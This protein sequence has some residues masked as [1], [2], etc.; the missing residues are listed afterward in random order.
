M[1]NKEDV[2]LLVY[3]TGDIHGD[4]E[5]FN[6]P[7][8]K[9]LKKGDTLI[10]CGDFGFI[11]NGGEVEAKALTKLSSKKFNICFVDGTHENFKIL[12]MA[13]ISEWNG[14]KVHHLGGNLYHLLRG[15]IFEIEGNTYFTM[16]GGESPDMEIRMANNTWS[17]LEMPSQQEL[18]EGANNI[19][20]AGGKV[21]YII[22]HEPSARIKDF[23][24]LSNAAYKNRATILNT[25]LEELANS[26]EYKK[27]YFGSMHMDKHISNS[28]TAVFNNVLEVTTGK[29]I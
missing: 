10:I 18:V 12:N 19:D 16:G 6:S 26:C 20:K 25:Y 14:G 24:Q 11:W 3:V 22:T 9:K 17:E 1:E 23:I 21:D 5:R 13:E 15:Q 2:K 4:L 7:A 8:M 28:Q 27:W 29:S